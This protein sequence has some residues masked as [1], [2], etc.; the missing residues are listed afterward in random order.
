MKKIL[1]LSVILLTTLSLFAGFEYE[2]EYIRLAAFKG[3]EILNPDH[4][5]VF[6]GASGWEGTY[7]FFTE[8][9]NRVSEKNRALISKEIKDL[10]FDMIPVIIN[11]EILKEFN[12]HGGKVVIGSLSTSEV[13]FTGNKLKGWE[14]PYNQSSKSMAPYYY[15]KIPKLLDYEIM[16]LIPKEFNES[17][18]YINFENPE[19]RLTIPS[20]SRISIDNRIKCLEDE[21]NRLEASK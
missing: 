20:N 5:Y 1:I 12:S 6:E 4:S 9:E 19:I 11:V 17:T 21:I 3:W 13:N 15:I 16:F 14:K 2:D 8:Q 10:F 7:D 18:I